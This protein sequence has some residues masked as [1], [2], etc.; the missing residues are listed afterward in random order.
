MGNYRRSLRAIDARPRPGRRAPSN[1]LRR[2][3]GDSGYPIESMPSLTISRFL[4][5]E[6]LGA[7][8][9]YTY[10]G[11]LRGS[12]AGWPARAATMRCC[13]D[14]SPQLPDWRGVTITECR[15]IS[16]SSAMSKLRTPTSRT[17]SITTQT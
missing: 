2:L 14:A 3:K 4:A 9:R 7:R 6:H 15:W 13:G 10:N 16:L 5:E 1:T 8:A 12:T 11:H 17:L